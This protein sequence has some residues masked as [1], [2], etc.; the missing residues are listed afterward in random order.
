MLKHCIGQVTQ[1]AVVVLFGLIS[2]TIATEEYRVLERDV[3]ASIV[4]DA[5]NNYGAKA[6]DFAGTAFDTAKDKAEDTAKDA[7]NGAKH[8]ICHIFC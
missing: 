4:D 7:Y 2:Q 5:V 3:A 8:F 6:Q 1:Y